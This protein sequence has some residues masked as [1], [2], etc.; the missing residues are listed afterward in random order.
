MP[1][2][3]RPRIAGQTWFF[4]VVTAERAPILIQAPVRAALRAAIIEIRQRH[5]FVIDAWVLLPDHL[6]CI[7]TL[8]E[9]DRDISSRWSMIKRGVTQRLA[10]TLP[11]NRNTSRRRRR[12]SGIWQRRFWDHVIRDDQDLLNHLDYIHANPLRHG[13]VTNVAD[14]PHS[15]FHRYV[16][17]GLYPQGW[18]KYI[19]AE[20]KNH[21]E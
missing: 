2:Y 18:G 12:E 19:D 8:P 16:K 4:T 10:G 11:T 15:S 6:H 7:W 20:M 21:G 1:Q 3:R 13:L 5:P 17:E 9:Q 14:W